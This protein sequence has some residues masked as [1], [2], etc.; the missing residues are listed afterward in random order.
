MFLRNRGV[1][2]ENGDCLCVWCKDRED[3][4]NHVLL[5]CNFA[6]IVWCK[7]FQRWD[8]QWVIPNSIEHLFRYLIWWTV[9]MAKSWNKGG[10]LFV[11]RCYGFYWL[12]RNDSI[13]NDKVL[14]GDD[15]GVSSK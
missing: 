2:P 6:W 7:I 1:L 11:V 14:D 15:F 3:Q 5:L 12:T 4:G 8:I 9:F 13:F 10:W